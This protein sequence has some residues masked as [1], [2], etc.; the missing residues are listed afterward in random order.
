V[1]LNGTCESGVWSFT[2][3][4]PIPKINLIS[5]ENNSVINDF[6][7]LLSWAVEYDGTEI[8]GYNVYFGTSEDPGI[9]FKNHPSTSCFIRER[10]VAGET[11]YWK[12]VPWAGN[13]QGPASEI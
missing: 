8:L 9:E 2:V 5:P 1:Q 11:Y 6:Q 10:L 13:I 4:I 7:P 12:V 3:N